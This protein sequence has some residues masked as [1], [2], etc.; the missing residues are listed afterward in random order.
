MSAMPR[1][2]V[3]IPAWNSAPFIAATLDSVAAQ[4]TPP[5]EVVVADDGS[6]DETCAV[7]EAFEKLHPHL[8]LRLLRAPHLGPGAAR[9]QAIRAATADWIAFLDS[10]DLWCPGKLAAI[11]TAILAHPGANFFCHNETVRAKSG[12]ERRTD[13]G[14]DYLPH[15]SLE[16]QL[17][18]RN[19]FSTS[20]VVCR[21]KLVLE[22]GGFDEELSSAQDYELWLRIS[23]DLRPVFVPE[24]LGTYVLRKGNISSSRYWIRLKNIVRVKYRHRDKVGFAP[25]LYFLFRAVLSH[26]VAP[27]RARISGY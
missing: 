20:A 9:N 23:P 24:T 25:C 13:Y 27:I 18:R 2:S 14:G 7:V 1:I 8:S 22:C 6:N 15:I 21:R 19:L 3:I 16:R 5:A 26:A 11:T 4:T 17:Y 12:G 10:D